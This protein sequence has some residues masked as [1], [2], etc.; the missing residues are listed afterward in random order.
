MFLVNFNFISCL[1]LGLDLPGWY[2]LEQMSSIMIAQI[3]IDSTR[4][5]EE[6]GGEIHAVLV[7]CAILFWF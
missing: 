6:T 7:V 2:H 3:R 5:S 1:A 4:I